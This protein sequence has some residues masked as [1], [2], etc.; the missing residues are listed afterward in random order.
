MLAQKLNFV[1]IYCR[2]NITVRHFSDGCCQRNS[3]RTEV[4]HANSIHHCI[5]A[6]ECVGIGITAKYCTSK[7]REACSVCSWSMLLRLRRLLL[8]LLLLRLLLA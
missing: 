8:L 2:V 7:D 1:C 5:S 6:S 4:T 3:K